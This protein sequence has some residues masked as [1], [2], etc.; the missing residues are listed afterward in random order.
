MGAARC[1]RESRSLKDDWEPAGS[2]GVERRF[3]FKQKQCAE[4]YCQKTVKG[5]P[6]RVSQFIFS[7]TL[8]CLI[9]EKP[10]F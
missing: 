7:E 1:S 10:L 4:L 9:N 2:R 3:E 8:C 5:C 6:L